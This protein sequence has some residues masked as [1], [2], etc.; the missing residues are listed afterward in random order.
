MS[1]P[2]FN[3]GI[4]IAFMMRRKMIITKLSECGAFSE[5]SAVSLEQAGVFNPNAFSGLTK[6]MEKMN[7]LT[8]TKDGKY[9]L[10]K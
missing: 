4:P 5:K 6:R 1:V 2:M 9:Y 7:V 3:M 8:R 10:N